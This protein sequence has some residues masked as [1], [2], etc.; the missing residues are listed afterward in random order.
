[1]EN[2]LAMSINSKLM[3]LIEDLRKAKKLEKVQETLDVL[4]A[5]IQNF[6][7]NLTGGTNLLA[8]LS[9]TELRVASM[10]KNGI[11]SQEIADKLHISLHTIK[12]H[13]RNIRKKLHLKNSQINLASYLRSIMW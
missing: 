13:R 8:P 5:N 2:T 10:I 3:P 7:N 12:T 6:N 9:P 4:V 11:A 1:M